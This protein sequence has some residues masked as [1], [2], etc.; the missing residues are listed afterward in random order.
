MNIY[1]NIIN[2]QINNNKNYC[3]LDNIYKND[4]NEFFEDISS[5]YKNKY[6]IE[7]NNKEYNTHLI[8]KTDN[9][10]ITFNDEKIYIEDIISIKKIN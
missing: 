6:L 8:G 10:L 1:K 7:T 4:I 5:I 9:Y 2:K 3:V